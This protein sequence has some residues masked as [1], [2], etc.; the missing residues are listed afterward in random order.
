MKYEKPEV[1]N[2][3]NAA[4]LILGTKPGSPKPDNNQTETAGAYEADE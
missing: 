3:N 4:D 1:L 2:V